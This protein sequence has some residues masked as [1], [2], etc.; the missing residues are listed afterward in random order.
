MI[1]EKYKWL[2]SII[3]ICLVFISIFMLTVTQKNEGNKTT[4]A[5]KTLGT[6]LDKETI[7]DVSID[8]DED[9]WK[10][11]LENSLDEE[12]R[13]CNITINGETYNNV[14]I[15]P[16]GNTSLT[17]VAN[18]D[19][20]DRYSFKIKFDKYVD[21]QTY[22]GMESIALNNIIQDNTYMKEYITYDLYDFFGVATPEMSYSNVKINDEDWGLYLA[23][24]I[25]DKRYLE[26][27]FGTSEGNL[28]K[29]ETMEMGGNNGGG[30]KGNPLNN[31]EMRPMNPPSMEN[32]KGNPQD[33]PPQVGNN[34]NN[35]NQDEMIPPGI[36]DQK[37]NA[38]INNVQQPNDAQRGDNVETNKDQQGGPNQNGRS[39]EGAD[40]V[41]IDDKVS[42]YSIVRDSAVFKETTDED[43]KRVINMF[44][45]LNDGTNLEDVLDVEE[46]LKYF[47][48]NTY[49]INLD[50]YSGQMYH[51][52]YLYE[53]DGKCQILPWDLNLSFGGFGA[54]GGN[55]NQSSG[56]TSVINF[57]IDN[58]VSGDLDNMPLIG[59]LLKVDKYKELYHS[60]LKQIADE[61]FNS[62]YYE[63]LVNKID[64]LI[65][66]YVEKDPTK[67]CT[68]EEYEASI[69][70]MI[71][72]GKDRTKSVLAQLNGEQPS[73]TYGNVESSINMSAL[74]SMGG[75]G[76]P[77]EHNFKQNEG[78]DNSQE[79]EKDQ[80]NKHMQ[81]G[82][83]K[84]DNVDNK[85]NR[86]S[87]NSLKNV[88]DFNK[89]NNIVKII[90]S[91]IF[92]VIGLV[93]VLFVSRFKRRG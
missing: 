11:L 20:T 80:E 29:P 44:K 15:R 21:G 48:V 64:S 79:S 40:F 17:S 75:G 2:I 77:G 23:V 55:Q 33:G 93:A 3:S 14:G 25:V 91:G 88:N 7:T 47:A 74:G 4:I 49:V 85:E 41:Y 76:K 51:N 70:Q 65:N 50:S 31:G 28:Y 38:D 35:I 53:K 57:P 83:L 12:Y 81:K 54:R 39:T 82:N 26:N 18:D 69:P 24:E 58:P 92:I 8:I 42:S 56:A 68:Y 78:K 59:Q 84:N 10:W 27:N 37:Q 62:G 45:N 6:V 90:S 67:F 1:K 16:K 32:G 22:K 43:F 5:Q 52:Y 46:V 13:S 30:Q 89:I 61:Y 36:N 71:A 19:T 87:S 73:T 9:D 72:F 60:Y 34:G 86:K 66:S 63:N